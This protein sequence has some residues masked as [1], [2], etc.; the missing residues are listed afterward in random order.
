MKR[1]D[2]TFR[3]DIIAM[4]RTSDE[5]EHNALADDLEKAG[6]HGFMTDDD[7]ERFMEVV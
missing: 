2:R 3:K 7:I 4:L 5:T 6:P 1:L